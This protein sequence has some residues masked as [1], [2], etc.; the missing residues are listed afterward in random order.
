MSL[1]LIDKGGIW[2]YLGLGML[3]A[4]IDG[5]ESCACS[6]VKNAL[7]FRPF[8]VGR[9]QTQLVPERQKT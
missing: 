2:I 1:D 6:Q 4:K 8:H 9:G 3:I 7:D 5:P